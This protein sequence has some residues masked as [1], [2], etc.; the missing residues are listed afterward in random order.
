VDFLFGADKYSDGNLQDYEFL[1]RLDVTDTVSIEL[2]HLDKSTYEYYRT[3][4]EAQESGGLAP[5]NPINNF[6]KDVL[7][8]FGAFSVTGNEVIVE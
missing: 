2:H 1:Q 5:A 8:Y 4:L 7:G 3:L 6:E